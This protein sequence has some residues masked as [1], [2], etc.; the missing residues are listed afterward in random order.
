MAI[1]LKTTDNHKAV[2]FYNEISA[3]SKPLFEHTPINFFNYIR[4][5]YDGR[6]LSMGTRPD[7]LLHYF[8]NQYQNVTFFNNSES[9]LESKF[10]GHFS[11]PENPVIY[12]AMK[13]FDICNGFALIQKK[14]QFVEYFHFAA[15]T[16]DPDILNFY[17]NNLDL[18]ERFCFYFKDTAKKLIKAA[19][20]YA[21]I[22]KTTS[23]TTDDD[24]SCESNIH[25]FL[26]KTPVNNIELFVNKESINV[27][28]A[29]Y[30]CLFLY[31]RGYSSKEIAQVIH[32]SHRT[33]E[34][35]LLNL[36]KRLMVRSKKEIMNIL[37]ENQLWDYANNQFLD[38]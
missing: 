5:Y 14:K 34:T 1:Q 18:L 23:I 26:N 9:C 19:K 8:E 37:H 13:N 25:E 24:T 10:L 30:M 31:V 4:I 29:E 28:F 21:P 32:K 17:F 20:P 33:V 11:N 35:Y 22:Q 27:N 7:W 15:P 16:L 36:K 6:R 38:R 3:I 12:D 2:S